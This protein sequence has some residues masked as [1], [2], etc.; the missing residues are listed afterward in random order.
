MDNAEGPEGILR[1]LEESVDDAIQTSGGFVSSYTLPISRDNIDGKYEGL[2]RPV[3]LG[4]VESLEST[5]SREGEDEDPVTDLR[6]I[7]RAPSSSPSTSAASSPSR[8][9]VRA[10]RR[11][12]SG[13]SP[14][15]GSLA[16]E[17]TDAATNMTSLRFLPSPS[18][19]KADAAAAMADAMS[20]SD[21]ILSAEPR[22]SPLKGSPPRNLFADNPPP[23]QLHNNTTV[24]SNGNGRG[25][26]T[27]KKKK[28]APNTIYRKNSKRNNLVIRPDLPRHRPH[29]SLSSALPPPHPLSHI[30]SY[31]P[32]K[33]PAHIGRLAH[34]NSFS[35]LSSAG[36]EATPIISPSRHHTFSMSSSDTSEE[37]DLGNLVGDE[38]PCEAI[39]R[40][41]SAT[42]LKGIDILC[43]A[44]SDDELLEGLPPNNDTKDEFSF[45]R[46]LSSPDNTSATALS[47]GTGTSS[48]QYGDCR[49]DEQ[50]M[51]KR[52][53]SLDAG[54]FE[55]IHD[56]GLSS[57][58]FEQTDIDLKTSK[59]A[60]IELVYNESDDEGSAASY[61]ED[62]TNEDDRKA[63]EHKIQKW[64]T[65][66]SMIKAEATA[67]A[68][69][70]ME[71]AYSEEIEGDYEDVELAPLSPS[72]N[73]SDANEH[74]NGFRESSYAS[75][76]SLGWRWRNPAVVV[77]T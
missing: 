61:E 71:Q 25:A 1:S 45:E 49:G 69:Q 32:S 8:S 34:S 54:F 70:S 67:V 47:T 18:V 75:N 64:R 63:I 36:S 73:G 50:R 43:F 29:K 62:P 48:E 23:Q 31:P 55:C 28:A 17:S 19:T 14:S 51:H 3:P 11:A 53:F 21:I 58:S 40:Q 42:D 74:S 56:S 46:Q 68:A 30:Q 22:I 60:E 9:P 37:G 16:S 76:N 57:R 20:G 4:R 41:I 2:M 77:K 15:A 26:G 27:R 44:E 10:R 65:H 5:S 13:S 66:R 39:P 7:F 59:E 6:G 33:S 12:G 38:G 24:D 72:T 35:D 52:Q